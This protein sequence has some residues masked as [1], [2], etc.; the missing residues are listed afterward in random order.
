MVYLF[1]KISYFNNWNIDYNFYL[2]MNDELGCHGH[3][4]KCPFN[5]GITIRDSNTFIG[6]CGLGPYDLNEKEIELYY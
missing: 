6:Y 1:M 3:V 2:R 4:Y 5:F